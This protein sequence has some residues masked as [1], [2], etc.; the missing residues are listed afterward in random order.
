MLAQSSPVA[1]AATAPAP[2]ESF[3]EFHTPFDV[4]PIV[5]DLADYFAESGIEFIRAPYLSW[6]Q[7]SYLYEANYIDAIYGPTETLLLQNVEKFILGLEYHGKEFRF[8]DK[9]KVLAEL[10]ITAHQLLEIAIS[11]GCDLQP[12]TFPFYQGAY[13]PNQ[14]FGIGLDIVNSGGSIYSSVLALNDEELTTKFQKG[15]I[16]LQFL[17]VLKL[18][19]RVELQHVDGDD[20]EATTTS[21]T[22]GEKIS[23]P[24]DLHEIIGQRLP[25]EYYFYQSI[26]LIDTKVLE[27]I[28]F[29][30]YFQLPPLETVITAQYKNTVNASVKL[31]KNKAIN[32]LTQNMTRYYQA[33][34]IKFAKSFDNVDVE[35][36]NRLPEPIFFKLS[37]LVVR[38][39]LNEFSLDAFLKSLSSGAGDNDDDNLIGATAYKV[40]KESLKLRTNHE[41]IAT[42]LLRTLYLLEYFDFDKTTSK[43]KPN[44]WTPTLLSLK[45]LD[46]R[47]QQQYI[48]LLNF[49]KLDAFDISEDLSSNLVG[50]SKTKDSANRRVVQLISRLA[51]YLHANQKK[52]NYVG[53][54]SR[55]LLS[56]RSSADVIKTNT[57][58]LLESV[59]VNSLANDE[60]AKLQKSKKDWQ[61]LVTQTPFRKVTPNTILGIA[62]QLLLD[63]YYSDD[64]T[65]A[66]LTRAKITTLEHFSNPASSLVDLASDIDAVFVFVNE[67]FKIVESLHKEGLVKDTLYSVFERANELAKRALK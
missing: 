6:V 29:G 27:A 22:T 54:I 33:K 44:K 60:V 11:V 51:T 1:A 59:L 67:A 42:S 66:S 63:A 2:V 28:V 3:R 25:H 19:G 46:V 14:L 9:A 38:S 12:V 7:L 34:K 4:D 40:D 8:V 15:I 18:N 23:P 61:S 30:T 41:V 31:F 24:T 62:T 58:E 17:P 52:Q 36:V 45:D 20:N 32:L 39:D 65:D 5:K 37:P 43:I 48:L 53:P 21:T 57:S 49:F 35:L 55:S 10:N 26:A 50:G 13:H 56:F 64:E 47:F 16:A